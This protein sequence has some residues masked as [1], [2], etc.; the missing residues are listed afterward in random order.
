M[1]E[2][3]HELQPGIFLV[4]SAPERFKPVFSV[5]NKKACLLVMA[6]DVAGS[7]GTK[8]GGVEGTQ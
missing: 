7:V 4:K 5:L 1:A 8:T 6:M 3:S 2:V